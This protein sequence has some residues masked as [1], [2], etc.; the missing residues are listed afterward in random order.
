L[1]RQE[2]I[3]R[4]MT[5]P[6]SGVVTGLVQRPAPDYRI[7]LI[8]IERAI[9][10]VAD[11]SE[12]SPEGMSALRGMY[13]HAYMVR[14]LEMLLGIALER[15]GTGLPLFEVDESVRTRLDASDEAL[16]Q[17]AISALR[18]NEYAG[19]VLPPG[20]RFRFANSPGLDAM[21]YV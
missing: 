4:W 20:V 18:Q 10:V 13:R 19:G 21:T 5:L 17:D 2:S 7:R 14:N 15:F 16:L 1:R 8:P 9:H 6:D 3:E 11:D 12:G